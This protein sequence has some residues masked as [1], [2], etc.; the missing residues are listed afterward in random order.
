[1]HTKPYEI[2]TIKV[3]FSSLPRMAATAQ[4]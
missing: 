4:P 1:L 3:R 2:K